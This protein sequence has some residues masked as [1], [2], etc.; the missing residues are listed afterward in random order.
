MIHSSD[1]CDVC[2]DA[3]LCHTVILLSV[4]TVAKSSKFQNKREYFAEMKSNVL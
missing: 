3:T 4:G 2:M 1:L